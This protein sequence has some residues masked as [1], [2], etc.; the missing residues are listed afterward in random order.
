MKTKKQLLRP[1]ALSMLWL[2]MGV[3]CKKE[4]PPPICEDSIACCKHWLNYKF[5][6][7]GYVNGELAALSGPPD[8]QWG[9]TLE[10]ARAIAPK[11]PTEAADICPS[12]FDKIAN[13]KPS[14]TRQ[15]R[16]Y[17]Y[18]VWGTLYDMNVPTLT[19]RPDNIMVIDRIEA[20]K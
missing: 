4:E 11:C 10:A 13:L 20:V 2:S 19:C 18:R 1:L 17:A 5:P 16:E 8:F 3:G 12:S 7:V 9:L 6:V 15:K 14:A